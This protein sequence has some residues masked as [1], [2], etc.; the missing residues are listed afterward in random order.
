MLQQ[1]RVEAVIPYY[2]RWMERF[3]DVQALAA[4]SLGEVLAAWEGLGYYSRA[5]NLHKAAQIVAGEM[6]GQIPSEC[7]A[8][9]RL[10][11]I[12][13]YTAGA[14][15]SIAYGK[16]EPAVDGN[17]KRVLS[18]FFD[19]REPLSSRAAEKRFKHLSAELLPAG[20]AGEFNQALMDLGALVCTPRSPL[21]TQCPLSAGCQAYASGVQEKRPVKLP[22]PHIPHHTVTAAVILHDGRVLIAQR[23]LKGLLGGLWEFPGG[24]SLPGEKLTD[25]LEREIKE[26]LG[27]QVHVGPLL[28]RYRH[29]YTHFRL[30]LHAFCCT[31]ANGGEPTPM[32]SQDLR[33]VKLTELPDF[34]MGKIDRQISN[35]LLSGEAQIC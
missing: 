21:C 2:L 16:D 29:A 35:D 5:R 20:R 24:K 10:P 18:R 32:Q 17:L 8:L 25:C 33:W 31:L 28:G 34:P 26:E 30:T 15:A 12:G 11:G 6:S 14:I 13:R 7:G 1:T 3:P 9:Q 4:A 27:V 19:I 23:P 22:K